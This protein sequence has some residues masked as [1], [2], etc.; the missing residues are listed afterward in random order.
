MACRLHTSLIR[1]SWCSL[2]EP[3]L[4]ISLPTHSTGT[5][6]ALCGSCLVRVVRFMREADLRLAL[7]MVSNYLP[8]AE[9]ALR[10]AS[11]EWTPE[12]AALY[13]LLVH[14]VEMLRSEA[15]RL[16]DELEKLPGN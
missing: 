16:A 11:A 10:R 12:R 9:E 4:A 5:G 6:R 1:H 8:R 3:Y 2:P 7:R 13:R 15:L 14:S